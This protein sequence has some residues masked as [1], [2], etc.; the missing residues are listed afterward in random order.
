[1]LSGSLLVRLEDHSMRDLNC[2]K[3]KIKSLKKYNVNY[4][5]LKI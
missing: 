1:M 2:I 4:L 3:S 5:A